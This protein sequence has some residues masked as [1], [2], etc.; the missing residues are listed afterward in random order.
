MVEC[1]FYQVLKGVK[2]SKT[3]KVERK[4]V[5]CQKFKFKKFERYMIETTKG[6]MEKSRNGQMSKG[7]KT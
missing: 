5:E 1:N 2:M 4:K 7:R 3:K 6:R